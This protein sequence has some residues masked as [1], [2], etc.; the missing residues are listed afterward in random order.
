FSARTRAGTPKNSGSRPTA[1]MPPP[2]PFPRF[3]ICRRDC[4]RWRPATASL[5][6][7]PMTPQPPS[8][9]TGRTG[10]C[11]GF[12]RKPRE[13]RIASAL[14]RGMFHV[15]RGLRGRSAGVGQHVD[16]A[17]KLADVPHSE[18]T[19]QLGELPLEGFVQAADATAAP[20][21][22]HE[23][24]KLGVGG[25]QAKGAPAAALAIAATRA[26]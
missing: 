13:A 20:F 19:Q 14:A 9:S 4:K 18:L 15:P 22:F 11:G 8:A 6:A 5:E 3:R 26:S 23:L 7:I 21:R 1:A 2:L 17:T 25:G 16:A 12:S 10:A 24:R